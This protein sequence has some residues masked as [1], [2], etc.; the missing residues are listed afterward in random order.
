MSY[1][2]SGLF[3]LQGLEFMSLNSF[4][5]DLVAVIG[6]QDLVFGEVDR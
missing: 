5:A 3:T 6:T 2:S 4:L 1:K